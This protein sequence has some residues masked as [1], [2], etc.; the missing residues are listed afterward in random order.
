MRAAFTSARVPERGA[1]TGRTIFSASSDPTASPRPT[2]RPASVNWTYT[3]SPSASWPTASPP[4]VAV[5]RE[6]GPHVALHVVGQVLGQVTAAIDQ[7]ALPQARVVRCQIS[8]HRV[9]NRLH[10]GLGGHDHAVP[11]APPVRLEQQ[12]LVL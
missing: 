12:D 2:A 3:T 10:D 6:P 8:Q 1:S 4:P 5:P 9:G 7:L 11:R